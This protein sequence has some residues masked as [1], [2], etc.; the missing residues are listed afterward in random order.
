M[1][2]ASAVA[3]VGLLLRLLSE[4]GGCRLA[5]AAAGPAGGD[6]ASITWTGRAFLVSHDPQVRTG[7]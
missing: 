1:R 3:D 7:S 2:G 4:M 5:C 6:V